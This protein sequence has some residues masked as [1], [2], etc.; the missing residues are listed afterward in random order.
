[1]RCCVPGGSSC[2]GLVG[3]AQAALLQA[4]GQELLQIKTAAA[5]ARHHAS[6]SH[7]CARRGQ[8]L[9]LRTAPRGLCIWLRGGVL[10]HTT[11]WSVSGS[12]GFKPLEVVCWRT[13]F[14]VRQPLLISASAQGVQTACAGHHAEGRRRRCN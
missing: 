9:Q 11:P 10:F 7:G 8:H 1:M 3:S 14:G 6:P 4:E 5:A 12:M 13:A 2:C